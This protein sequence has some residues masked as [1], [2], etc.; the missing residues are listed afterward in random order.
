[1]AQQWPEPKILFPF[2]DFD[3]ASLVSVDGVIHLHVNYHAQH[4]PDTVFD[5]LKSLRLMD[6]QSSDQNDT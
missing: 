4:D 3:V 2:T 1:V 6:N 5:I